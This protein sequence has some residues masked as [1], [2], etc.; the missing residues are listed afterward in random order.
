MQNAGAAV[1]RPMGGS[2]L[3]SWATISY[4]QLVLTQSGLGA[5]STLLALDV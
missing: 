3:Q 5:I 2:A 1:D 4:E